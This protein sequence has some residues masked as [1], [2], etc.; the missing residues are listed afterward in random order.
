MT[1]EFHRTVD[2]DQVRRRLG[3]V[4]VW[5]AALGAL[6]AGQ[7]REQLQHIEELGYSAVWLTEMEKEAFAHSALA[8]AA[9]KTITVAT[10]IANMWAREPETAASGANAL[11]ERYQKPLAKAREY[12]GRMHDAQLLGTP[13]PAPTPWLVAALR[14]KMLELSASQAQGAHPYFVP[15]EHTALAR[16]IIG[17]DA[18]LA[19]ELAVVLDPNPET[20]RATARG[21]MTLYLALPNYTNNLLELG[22]TDDDFASGGSDRL[23]DA[24][25]AWGDVEAIKRRVDDHLAAGADH[26]CIQPLTDTDRYPG[27]RFPTHELEELAP[28]LLRS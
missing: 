26:V 15:P 14:T 8:L 4:G 12:L 20:A 25:V 27:G 19:P 10:G 5:S 23:V 7:E 2:L 11:V 3:R 16:K 9:T 24:V 1:T 17:P 18:I 22:F 13:A 28:A 21:Y 6:P